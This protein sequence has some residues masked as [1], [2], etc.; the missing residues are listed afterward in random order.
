[1]TVLKPKSKEELGEIINN[2]PN[3]IFIDESLD[4][5]SLKG[6]KLSFKKRLM[7]MILI[8]YVNVSRLYYTHFIVFYTVCAISCFLLSN[9]HIISKPLLNA[10]GFSFLVIIYTN[11][12]ILLIIRLWKKILMKQKN[13]HDLKIL[14]DEDEYQGGD[15]NN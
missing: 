10:I 1:M 9:K 14:N 15:Y 3:W 6:A 4:K 13:D 7:Y 8:G 12:L 2:S 11:L 5:V